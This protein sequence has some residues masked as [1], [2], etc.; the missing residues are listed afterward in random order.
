VSDIVWK[1]FYEFEDLM[2]VW[3]DADLPLVSRNTCRGEA[4]KGLERCAE[5]IRKRFSKLLVM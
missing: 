4:L 3:K 1:A 5:E 2:I